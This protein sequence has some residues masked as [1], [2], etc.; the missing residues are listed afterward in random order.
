[1]KCRE[2]WSGK[3]LNLRGKYF[4]E[5]KCYFLGGGFLLSLHFF[6]AQR[7]L[8]I[9]LVP[10]LVGILGLYCFPWIVLNE[11]VLGTTERSLF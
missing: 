1:M 4:I 10:T 3:Q 2:L 8:S 6:P 5:N 11:Q 9:V 7:P